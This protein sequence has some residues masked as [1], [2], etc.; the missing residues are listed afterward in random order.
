MNTPD[1]ID[2]YCRVWSDPDPA[3]RSRLLAGAWSTNASYSDPTVFE[4]DAAALLAHIGRIQLTRPGARVLRSTAVDTHHAFA[5]FGFKVVGADGTLL[6]EGMDFVT[7]S[8]DG[9]RIEQVVGFFGSLHA[10]DA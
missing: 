8:S 5:R 3:E 2:R 9:L 7:L 4:L 1:L 10:D 6:R